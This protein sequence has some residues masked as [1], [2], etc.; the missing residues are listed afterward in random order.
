MTDGI[1][2]ILLVAD[3]HLGFDMPFRPRVQKQRR[4]PDF[5]ANFE[6]ALKPALCEQVDLAVHGGG[7][8]L[9]Q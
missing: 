9:S 2:R 8:I 3:T 1:I 4:G 6:S 7:F 5:F